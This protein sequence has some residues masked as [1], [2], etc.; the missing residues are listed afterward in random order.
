MGSAGLHVFVPVKAFARHGKKAG[1]RFDP[2][3][4][5]ELLTPR[6]HACI[7]GG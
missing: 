7:T 6:H 2:S 3:T 4:G 5:A 1:R